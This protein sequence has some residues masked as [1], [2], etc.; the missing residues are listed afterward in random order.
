VLPRPTFSGKV[1]LFLK[2]LIAQTRII[3]LLKCGRAGRAPH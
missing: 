3:R 1:T 2:G